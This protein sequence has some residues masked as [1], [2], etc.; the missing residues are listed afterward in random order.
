[1]EKYTS[2]KPIYENCLILAPDDEP[3]CRCDK[4][5]IDWYLSRN[6]AEVLQEDPA[7][8][9]LTFQ[10]NGRGVSAGKGDPQVDNLYYVDYKPG[11]RNQCVVC[12]AEE[13]YM[14]FH[15]VPSKYRCFFPEKYKA[16]RS[17]DILLL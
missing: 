1:M 17:H 12:G 9:R 8:I 16:H 6:L 13:N 7:I 5:K 10:P 11:K 2:T 4:K 14:R 15:I 3:L